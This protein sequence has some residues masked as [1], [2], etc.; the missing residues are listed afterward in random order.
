MSDLG[1][2]VFRVDPSYQPIMRQIGLDGEAVFS[3]PEIKVWRSIPER[4]NCTLDATLDGREIRL[5]IKRYRATRRS[6]TPADEEARGIGA[7][8]DHQIPTVPLV[9]WGRLADGRSFVITED[10]ADFRAADKVIASGFSFEKLLFP[11]ADLV[12]KLHS[13][14]LHHRDLY[15]CHFFVKAE[16]ERIEL[17]LIDAAR[18][19]RLP[20]WM[21]NR[22]IVK[23]LAQFWYSA[24]QLGVPR[25]QLIQ[26]LKRY[27][28]VR[29]LADVDRLISAIDRK[30]NWIAHHDQKLNRAQPSRN[31]SIPQA[32]GT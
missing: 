28:T 4:E 14:G 7:L 13:F 8:L 3:H 21:K 12:A 10:L 6:A 22:W 23:D 16:D 25:E 27:G 17:R 24:K 32:R 15:L 31:V 20:R 30:V 9:G 26:W 19:R 11:T 29:N 5:H 1:S 18:V 2:D